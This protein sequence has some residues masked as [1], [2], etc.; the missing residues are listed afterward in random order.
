MISTGVSAVLSDL[1]QEEGGQ[2]LVEYGLNICLIAMLLV[3]VM[4]AFGQ[5]IA[6]LLES[7]RFIP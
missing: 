3:G 1:F 6:P 2:G 7:V 5:K 4:Y